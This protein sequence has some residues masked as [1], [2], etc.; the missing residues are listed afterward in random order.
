M[1]GDGADAVPTVAAGG[2]RRSRRRPRGAAPPAPLDARRASAPAWARARAAVAALALA[3]TAS[4]V[5]AAASDVAARRAPAASASSG[6]RLPPLVVVDAAGALQPGPGWRD[7]GWPDQAM[8]P[9]RYDAVR[10]D[11][12]TA[13]RL[14]AR[15]SYGNRVLDVAPRPAPRTLR[16]SWRIDE[17]NAAVDLTRK[18]GDDTAARICLGFDLP[19]DAV[20]FVDRQL[21]RLARSRSDRPLPAATLCWAWAHA[22][23][24]GVPI[25]NAYTRRVRTIPLRGAG[26]ATGRWLDEERDVAA[27]FRLAFGDEAAGVPPLVAV[28]VAADADNTGGRSLAHV[29]DLA[30]GD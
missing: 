1:R 4:A 5:A 9:T 15:A 23:P 3:V 12:R 17:P 30:F 6:P 27:D 10:V 21:L 24:R 22:E 11:G 29:A 14:D 16:W 28:I 2:L 26:D 7:V 25:A 19:L 20:P 18:S 13:L 8:P